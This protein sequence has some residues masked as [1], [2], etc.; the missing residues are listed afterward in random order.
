MRK[1]TEQ[2][3]GKAMEEKFKKKMIPFKN[4]DDTHDLF[5]EAFYLKEDG[6]ISSDKAGKLDI[7]KQLQKDEFTAILNNTVDR[8]V[9]SIR[10]KGTIKE[11][12]AVRAVMD[13]YGIKVNFNRRDLRKLSKFAKE[14]GLLDT[15]SKELGTTLTQEE[16][17][18]LIAHADQ[19]WGK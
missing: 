19:K 15:S 7:G 18:E 12:D 9:S 10:G 8:K 17:I 5:D 1:T 2:T 3:I 4:I 6:A 13:A 14:K 16:A 11:A